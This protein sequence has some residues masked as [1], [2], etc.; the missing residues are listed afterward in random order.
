MGTGSVAGTQVEW[1][2][3][4]SGRR[5]RIGGFGGLEPKVL[6]LGY[7]RAVRRY[8]GYVTVEGAGLRR[9]TAGYVTIRQGALAERSVLV[10]TNYM[11]VGR[12]L[13]IYQSAEVDLRGPGGQGRGGLGY[14]FANVRITPR[15][16]CE[17]RRIG[18]PAQGL[19]AAAPAGPGP[20]IR[21]PRDTRRGPGRLAPVAGLQVGPP[22]DAPSG[23]RL[24]LAVARP[25]C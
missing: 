6:E 21:V 17:R 22:L 11:P 14:V 2:T 3:A 4:A 23:A 8:G 1:R 13:F 19:A 18:P 7:A 24:S 10:T 9:H 15:Q 16:R 12:R 20:L 5:V 25:E